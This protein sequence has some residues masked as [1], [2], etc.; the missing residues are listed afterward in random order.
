M[1]LSSLA[2]G[3]AEIRMDRAAMARKYVPLC[4]C[5]EALG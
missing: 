4:K 1:A 3:V 2:A 5:P